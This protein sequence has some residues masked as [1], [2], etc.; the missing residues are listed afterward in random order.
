M[1]IGEWLRSLGLQSYEQTFRDN[2]FDLEI[3]PHLTVED[4]KESRPSA[5]GGSFSMQSACY[6]RTWRR[7]GPPRRWSA[8][9]S[10]SCSST[11]SA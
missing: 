3:L 2:G 5:T 7:R 11:S 10:R 6:Q 1:D 9:S 8:D 4:L